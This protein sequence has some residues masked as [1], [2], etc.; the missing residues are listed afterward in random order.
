[1]LCLN[2]FRRLQIDSNEHAQHSSVSCTLSCQDRV[3]TCLSIL[4]SS[5]RKFTFRNS[6]PMALLTHTSSVYSSGAPLTLLLIDSLAFLVTLSFLPS[7]HP[8]PPS[9]RAP[10]GVLKRLEMDPALVYN[11]IL[12][13]GLSTFI[14]A[15]GSYAIERLGGTD[16]V[17]ANVWDVEIPAYLMKS[18][19]TSAQ[20]MEVSSVSSLPGFGTPH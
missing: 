6:V 4:T 7:F 20:M 10:L 18:Q 3:F 8:S 11:L 16:F 19:L 5:S 13:V 9:A 1:M 12:A 14:S 2:H 15:F 17:K